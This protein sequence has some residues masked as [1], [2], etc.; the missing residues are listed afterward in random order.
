MYPKRFVWARAPRTTRKSGIRA[1]PPRARSEPLLTL[2]RRSA[3]R[4]RMTREQSRL[5]RQLIK[6]C[7]QSAILG[8]WP[9]QMIRRRAALFE[10]RLTDQTFTCAARAHVATAARRTACL[11]VSR[12]MQA[13]RRRSDFDFTSRLGRRAEAGARQGLR[14]VGR[15][16][17]SIIASS[18]PASHTYA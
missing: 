5:R 9:H 15:P 2:E 12:A 11:H 17:P 13:A 14:G 3:N 7:G 16:R 4:D 6:Q 1:T 10:V 8:R 18:T